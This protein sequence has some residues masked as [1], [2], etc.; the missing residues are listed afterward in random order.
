MQ[1]NTPSQNL[2][3]P[4]T[5]CFH[6]LLWLSQSFHL[7][8]LA[9]DSWFPVLSKKAYHPPHQLF[10]LFLTH[11]NLAGRTSQLNTDPVSPS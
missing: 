3:H 9:S 5:P 11:A 8:F 4:H 10:I 2:R 6:F 1:C 7:Y